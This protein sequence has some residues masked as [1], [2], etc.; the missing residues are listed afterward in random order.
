MISSGVRSSRNRI[1][2]TLRA[3]GSMASTMS[4]IASGELVLLDLVGDR[5][6][7][8]S[9]QMHSERSAGALG[10]LG[11]CFQRASDT[12]WG[13]TRDHPVQ[14]LEDLAGDPAPASS[15]RII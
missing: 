3:R 2:H 8:V 9:H 5:Q 1:V 6:S 10:G 14:V 13:D 7:V 12:D 11:A 4:R 15:A